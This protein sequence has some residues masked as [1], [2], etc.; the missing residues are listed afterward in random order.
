[1]LS[2]LLNLITGQQITA[3]KDDSWCWLEKNDTPYAVK[4]TY[5]HIT[6]SG[7]TGSS[8]IFILLWDN[9]VPL[10]V[11]AFCWRL[12]LD[13]IPTA[14]NLHKRG[15]MNGSLLCCFCK[16]ISENSY[17]LFLSCNFSYAVWMFIYNWLGLETALAGNMGELL[18]QH[19]GLLNRRRSKK[20]WKMSWFAIIWSIWMHMN[21]IIFNQGNLDFDKVTELI[22]IR[23]WSW[24]KGLVSEACFSFTV[25][26][27]NPMYCIEATL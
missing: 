27:I 12:I 13:P 4:T 26:C 22:K 15:V 16:A 14:E 10:K 18:S 11:W 8:E 25:W 20:I 6:E 21:E 5:A 3:D 23:V 1:M 24:C 2:T 19:V 17:H 7:H 9:K